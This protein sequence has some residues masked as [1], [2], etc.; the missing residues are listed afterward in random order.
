MCLYVI[1]ISK[2]LLELKTKLKICNNIACGK[3]QIYHEP[4]HRLFDIFRLF[5]KHE[6]YKQV[7]YLSFKPFDVSLYFAR[8]L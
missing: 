5:E 6:C 3:E 2:I 7:P 1:Y 4:E 8:V